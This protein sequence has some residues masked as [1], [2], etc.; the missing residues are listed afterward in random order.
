MGSS[1]GESTLGSVC[2]EAV[3]SCTESGTQSVRSSVGTVE[4]VVASPVGV[5][6]N[7]TDVSSSSMWTCEVAVSV[8]E[9]RMAVSF[10]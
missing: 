8:S 3:V 1:Y 2:A 9:T 7:V 4:A 10:R 6:W 5:A